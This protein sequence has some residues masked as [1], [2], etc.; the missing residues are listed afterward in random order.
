M[1]SFARTRLPKLILLRSR[2]F[3]KHKA[4]PAAKTA[5]RESLSAV[6][7]GARVCAQFGIPLVL[8]A[9]SCDSMSLNRVDNSSRRHYSS[10]NAEVCELASSH[11]TPLRGFLTSPQATSLAANALLGNTPLEGVNN[12]KMCVFFFFVVDVFACN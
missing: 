2:H 5:L 11:S 4:T 9:K 1:R 12:L 8:R 3:K 10:G 7:D 6:R